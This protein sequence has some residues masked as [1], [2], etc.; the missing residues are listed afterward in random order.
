VDKLWDLYGGAAGDAIRDGLSE[1]EVFTHEEMI[2]LLTLIGLPPSDCEN[3]LMPELRVRGL[4]ER[5]SDTEWKRPGTTIHRRGTRAHLKPAW[6]AISAKSIKENDRLAGLLA[7]LPEGPY[8]SV[9]QFRDITGSF[10]EF[11]SRGGKPLTWDRINKIIERAQQLGVVLKNGDDD[12]FHIKH[13]ASVKLTQTKGHWQIGPKPAAEVVAKPDEK[14]TPNEIHATL[15]K[16]YS[17]KLRES[18]MGVPSLEWIKGLV[19]AEHWNECAARSCA[20]LSSN[21]SFKQYLDMRERMPEDLWDQL[22][23]YTLRGLSIDNLLPFAE[24]INGRN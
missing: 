3:H 6:E 13:D 11:T 14:S 12:Q 9:N 5:V 8:R 17:G 21:T 1:G 10:A 4:I 15:I 18:G 7:G 2:D 24:A 22:A 20:K 23:W 16:F 19:P